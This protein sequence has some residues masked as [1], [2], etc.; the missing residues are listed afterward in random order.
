[1]TE[2]Q[3]NTLY[4]ITNAQ[5][6]TTLLKITRGVYMNKTE[7]EIVD[8]CEEDIAVYQC[9]LEKEED[10]LGAVDLS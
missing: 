6:N 3:N 10:V 8:W 2:A 4:Q 5:K 1:M 7:Y 9:I